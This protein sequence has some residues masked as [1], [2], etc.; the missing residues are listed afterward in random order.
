MK[1]LHSEFGLNV[2]NQE[3][4]PVGLKSWLGVFPLVSAVL[5]ATQMSASAAI[6]VSASF[7]VTMAAIAHASVKDADNDGKFE[8]KQRIISLLAPAQFALLMWLAVTAGG[9]LG[10]TYVTSSMIAFAA[11]AGLVLADFLAAAVTLVVL[12]RNEGLS[13]LSLA[14]LINGKYSGLLGRLI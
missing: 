14:S 10:S 9:A 5:L 11:F 3:L 4:A 6:C 7:A 2:E 13:G 12:E 8:A 1:T